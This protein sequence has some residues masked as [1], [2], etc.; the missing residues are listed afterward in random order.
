MTPELVESTAEIVAYLHAQIDP[1]DR[2]NPKFAHLHA[3][4]DALVKAQS[5]ILA[6]Q[7]PALVLKRAAV[8]AALAEIFGGDDD[9]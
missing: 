8:E 3:A 7:V 2:F 1:H 5:D 4:I 9:E 6:Q